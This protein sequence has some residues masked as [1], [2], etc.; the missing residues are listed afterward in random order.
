MLQK[1]KPPKIKCFSKTVPII[2][3]QLKF[4]KLVMFLFFQIHSRVCVA[5]C[6]NQLQ[7]WT[8]LFLPSDLLRIFPKK[9]FLPLRVATK[10][11]HLSPFYINFNY[12]IH[13][14][15]N[16]YTEI[17]SLSHRSPTTYNKKY[18]GVIEQT[19]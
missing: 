10:I 18:L 4:Q 11:I 3:L 15:A 14:H 9:T 1:H 6:P 8:L 17:F 19:M 12:L 16:L 2:F 7:V 13:P 5:F